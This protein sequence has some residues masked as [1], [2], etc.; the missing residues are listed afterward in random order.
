M[1]GYLSTVGVAL[2]GLTVWHAV[3][4]SR[5]E[6]SIERHINF[7]ETKRLAK[8]GK[9]TS[10]SRCRRITDIKHTVSY[11]PAACQGN[12]WTRMQEL[13]FVLSYYRP[14]LQ[15]CLPNSLSGIDEVHL[16]L[17]Y[18]LFP[19]LCQVYKNPFNYGKLNNW[20][21]FLGVQKRR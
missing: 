7:K 8:R 5:G 17:C 10:C 13:L 1:I 9:V 15:L 18:L 3:L 21:V 12:L 14:V 6:T 20:K 11:L 2:G 19:S 16:I 4:I